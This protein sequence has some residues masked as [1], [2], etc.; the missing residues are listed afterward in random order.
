MEK[1]VLFCWQG[2]QAFEKA[3]SLLII[4]QELKEEVS[5]HHDVVAA[6]GEQC[7]D[8]EPWDDCSH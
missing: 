6:N 4:R 2:V 1:E 5:S 8:Q 3:G 7:S